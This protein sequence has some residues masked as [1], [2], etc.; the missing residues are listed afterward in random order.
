MKTRGRRGLGVLLLLLS[1]LVRVLVMEGFRMSLVAILMGLVRDRGQ[2]E[3]EAWKDWWVVC[4]FVSNV[5]W[6]V[7]GVFD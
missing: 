6:L 7:S 1:P 4:L 3:E 2:D 5:F